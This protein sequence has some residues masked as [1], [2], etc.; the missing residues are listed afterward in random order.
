MSNTGSNPYNKNPPCN[1]WAVW[2]TMGNAQEEYEKA[3]QAKKNEILQHKE[4]E[5]VFTEAELFKKAQSNIM[6]FTPFIS[7]IKV[8][9][10]V[11]DTV[12]GAW[13]DTDYKPVFALQN[14]LKYLH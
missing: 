3:L 7:G 6:K 1:N 13:S 8:I 5:M 2:N 14:E 12:T 10:R 4:N 9:P 11:Q